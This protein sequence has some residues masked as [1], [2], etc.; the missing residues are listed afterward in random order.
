MT[1]SKNIFDCRQRQHNRVDRAESSATFR[2][3]Q[4]GGA[5]WGQPDR[6]GRLAQ[7]TRVV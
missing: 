7:E 2:E 3:A 5:R 4:S 6:A 1:K